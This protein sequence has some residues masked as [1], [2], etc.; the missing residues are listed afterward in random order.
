MWNHYYKNIATVN[1]KVFH[2]N[3]TRKNSKVIDVIIDLNLREIKTLKNH[4]THTFIVKCKAIR[5]KGVY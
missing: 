3:L 5:Y 1:T 4:T 2:F